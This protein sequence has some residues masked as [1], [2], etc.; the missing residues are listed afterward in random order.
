VPP[1]VM[2]SLQV[3]VWGRYS[4]LPSRHS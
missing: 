4:L 1:G 2:A 3:I